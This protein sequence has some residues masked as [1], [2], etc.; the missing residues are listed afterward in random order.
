MRIL[1]P[2]SSIRLIACFLAGAAAGCDILLGIADKPRDVPESCAPSCE[3]A[4]CLVSLAGLE[5]V[6]PGIPE[7]ECTGFLRWEGD[8]CVAERPRL[9]KDGEVSRGDGACEPILDADVPCV[10]ESGGEGECYVMDPPRSGPSMFSTIPEAIAG[11]CSV[12]RVCGGNHGPLFLESTNVIHLSGYE[13]ARIVGAV[14]CNGV[15]AGIC[16]TGASSVTI[17]NL[18]VGGAES[19]VLQVG[20]RLDQVVLAQLHQ[21]HVAGTTV[22][23]VSA[24]RTRLELHDALLEPV[25]GVAV[26]AQIADDAEGPSLVVEGSV[27]RSPGSGAAGI[28]VER[29]GE[30]V[31]GLQGA[32]DRDVDVSTTLFEFLSSYGICS[33]GA[34]SRVTASAMREVNPGL[35]AAGCDPEVGAPSAGIHA[36][37]DDASTSLVVGSCLFNGIGGVGIYGHWTDVTIR[38]SA[39]EDVRAIGG[40]ARSGTAVH[41]KLGTSRLEIE[42]SALSGADRR[43]VHVQQGSF[44]I[45]STDLRAGQASSSDDSV[46]VEVAAEL[47]TGESCVIGSRIQGFGTAVRLGTSADVEVAGCELAGNGAALDG[48]VSSES[49]NCV[50][51]ASSLA[52]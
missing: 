28:H 46:G 37:G 50:D 20:V 45:A 49:H 15:E 44:V 24:S 18:G 40:D 34:H 21:V 10:P 9:C 3:A 8:T 26:A 12:I 47:D 11:R 5:C 32:D 41:A 31:V 38:G 52:P 39:F 4:E 2:R 30:P 1:T 22:A 19:G 27:I 33:R 25:S 7:E 17:Q 23:G 42:R 14:G 36:Q 29:K 35:P 16:V 13:G 51:G 48:M 6:T 43:G